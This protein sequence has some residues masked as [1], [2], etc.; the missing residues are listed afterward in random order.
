MQDL[1]LGRSRQPWPPLP[2]PG[3]VFLVLGQEARARVPTHQLVVGSW[4]PSGWWGSHAQLCN[5]K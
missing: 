1:T 5:A 3:A 2:E 4:L